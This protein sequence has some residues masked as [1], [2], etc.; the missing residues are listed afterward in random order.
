PLPLRPPLFPYTTL[1]RSVDDRGAH[2]V[3]STGGGIRSA[4]ELPAG[5][6]FG[7]HDLDP[8]EPDVLDLVDGDA[9]AVVA[10]F[11]G[12]V[13]VEQDLDRVAVPLESFVDGVV[14][15]LPEAVHEPAGVGGTDIHPGAL[16]HRLE[17][18]QNR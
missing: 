1:F 8:G 16:T 7:E 17:A 11:H 18:L 10:Y 13:R 15:D 6:E 5:V 4:A 2:P 14:D 3:Q 12:F 9:A